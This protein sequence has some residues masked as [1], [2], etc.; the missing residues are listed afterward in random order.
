LHHGCH[1][2]NRLFYHVLCQDVL[3]HH[4]PKAIGSSNHGLTPLEP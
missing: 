1:E 3:P 2:G 4:G